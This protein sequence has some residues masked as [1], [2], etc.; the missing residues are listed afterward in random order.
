MLGEQ[1]E[2]RLIRLRAALERIAADDRKHQQERQ[3]QG[4]ISDAKKLE[5]LKAELFTRIKTGMPTQEVTKAIKLFLEM[6]KRSEARNQMFS[7]QGNTLLRTVLLLGMATTALSI[8]ITFPCG[9]SRAPLCQTAR[10]IAD[11]VVWEFQ[12]PSRTPPDHAP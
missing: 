6:E 3:L 4:L 1:M 2:K 7:A 5:L 10:T 8:L 12:E 9:S 11:A